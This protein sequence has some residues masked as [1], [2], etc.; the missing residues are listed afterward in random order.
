MRPKS[1][2]STRTANRCRKPQWR[3]RARPPP[4]PTSRKHPD[5][6]HAFV[7]AGEPA[8]FISLGSLMAAPAPL[9]PL[10]PK[11]Y[12]AL[13]PIAGVRF[14]TIAAGLRYSGR[15][16]VMMALFDR[17]AAVAGVFTRSKCPSAPVDWCR[18]HLEGGK[19]RALI[20]NSG[21]ANAF[22][23]GVGAAAVAHVAEA[24]AKAIGAE[25]NEIFMASTG[26]IGEPLDATRITRVI[27]A[28]VADASE[29][30]LLG[31]AK[32][33]MTTDPYPKIATA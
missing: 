5:P 28:L 29:N 33:I 12:P 24:A 15:T 3:I 2:C 25:P 20:V 17:P 10:A 8:L 30:A 9:S 7:R 18:A 11:T 16:D 21:N 32:A 31:A 22:T 26:V 14:A 6:K 23:G 4:A 1:S 13:P 19:A 27:E